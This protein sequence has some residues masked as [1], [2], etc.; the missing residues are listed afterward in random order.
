MDEKEEYINEHVLK[1]SAYQINK[2]HPLR[3]HMFSMLFVTALRP[4]YMLYCSMNISKDNK[5]QDE[6]ELDDKKLI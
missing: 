3:E 4:E 2:S 6:I 5:E 1:Q